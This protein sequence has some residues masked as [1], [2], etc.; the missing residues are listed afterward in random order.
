MTQSSPI[1]GA[2]KSG[3]DYRQEDNDGKQALLNHHKGASAPSYAEAGTLWLDDTA[4]PW[5]LKMHDGADWVTLGALNAATNK[6]Q[7]YNG[8][9]QTV[10]DYTEASIA[11]AATTDLGTLSSNTALITG[12]TTI[13]SFG[14]SASTA[15]PLYFGRF[16][17]ALTLTH[18]ATSL[19]LPASA[20]ITTANGDSF[21]AEY[22]GSG[23][24]R[25]LGY[26]RANG[27]PVNTGTS[28]AT[29]P[30]LDGVNSWSSQQALAG[31]LYSMSA[32]IADDAAHGFISPIT[33]GI[34]FI[35]GGTNISA[36]RCGMIAVKVN[37]GTPIVSL[38]IGSGLTLDTTSGS[39][40]GTT[41]TDGNL[42]VRV[43]QGDGKVYVENRLGGTGVYAL[44]FIGIA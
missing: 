8:T 2:N 9:A 42:T 7:P 17:G 34:L 13:T 38:S 14:S 12:T 18:H 23:N 40:S 6:F 21:V 22:L 36:S 10:T 31:G 20:N 28:G 37:S 26:F 41:G 27:N 24:W 30:L 3:L 44:T 32:S 39:L 1:I 43:D 11:S 15:R 29:V 5:L 25:V 4:T 19:V 33:Q 16:S 35:T